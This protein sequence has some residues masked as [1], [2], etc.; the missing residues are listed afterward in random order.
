MRLL[1]FLALLL[2]SQSPRHWVEIN[3]ETRQIAQDK[4]DELQREGDPG[5]GRAPAVFR[6]SRLDEPVYYFSTDA[7]IY[8]FASDSSSDLLPY[9][10]SREV[11]FPVI[12]GNDAIGVVRLKATSGSPACY[13]IPV[14]SGIYDHVKD[15]LRRV[16]L[17]QDQQLS[18][19]SLGARRLLPRE[20]GK[21]IYRMAPCT[22]CRFC[23]SVE[24]PACRR[25]ALSHRDGSTHQA[26]T[27]RW[28]I[29][30]NERHESNKDMV[31]DRECDSICDVLAGSAHAGRVPRV[32]LDVLS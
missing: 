22:T 13:F 27:P 21:T 9:L 20:D 8:S 17:D 2:A 31:G 29:G 12:S 4:L 32:A 24:R 3:S 16:R 5:S 11:M 1:M 14:P 28:G 19:A 15:A 30:Y 23:C 25:S 26:C 6:N 7:G 18:I 10:V